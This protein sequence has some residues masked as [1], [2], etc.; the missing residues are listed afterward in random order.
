M[1]IE[2]TDYTLYLVTDSTMIP[3]SSTFLKQVEDSINNGATVVQLR[4][5][6][7]LTLEFIERASKVHELTSKR[8]I[9]LIINDRVDVALAID[10]DGVH[11]GQDD[12]PASTVRKLIGPNKIIG[13]SCSFPNEIE[14]V[15]K[16]S[17]ADYV[18]LGAVFKTNTKKDILVPEGTG[19]L[20]VR[21]ML[22][23]LKMHNDK[24][25]NKRI[26]S[27][28]IGGIN[29]SNASRVLYQTALPGQSLDGV[30]VVSCVMASNDAAKA[31]KELLTTIKS[32]VHWLDEI[33][34]IGLHSPKS[35][36][37]KIKAVA[38]SKPLIH[39]IT[40]NVVKNFSANVTLSIGAS[41]IMS[42]LPDEFEE[43][44][45]VI[46]NLALVLNLGTPS[47]SQMDVFKHAISVYNKH[48]KHIIF[49]PVA[50]GA[51]SARFNCCRELLN[52]GQFSVI[53]GN[54]GEI[55]AIWKLSSKHQML[56]NSDDKLLM[57][58]VD[59]IADLH[60]DD[61]IKMGKDVAQD[62][63]T[64]VVV[65][66][67]VNYVIDGTYV[68]RDSSKVYEV[69]CPEDINDIQVTK[70]PGGHELMGSIT[71]TGCS[72]GSTIAAFVAAKGDGESATTFNILEAVI[73]AVTLYNKCGKQA[74]D[75]TNSPGSFMIEFLDRL[76]LE[77][78]G[79]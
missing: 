22:Q 46:P 63:R 70:I 23:V 33:S 17:V 58:G 73:G 37:P 50:A 19:P 55:L 76:Y 56:G 66:G 61:I 47:A 64:V 43:F 79:K 2:N 31:T 9:P 62:F 75:L 49:D 18:G 45:T 5:K 60:E 74:G 12:M 6:N 4:E 77:T 21:L 8:G 16:E 13:V 65:T 24:A 7:L 35:L 40:N 69:S 39:H 72:L 30:A 68:D 20:G 27:V 1:S 51:S 34:S 59:S 67:A 32:P 48:G 11:V 26:K 53:K 29:N 28:A 42:E 44:A 3:E 10:A 41:P 25:R 36:G 15:C 54:V 38:N 52:A 78:H 71:G 14:V 57:H